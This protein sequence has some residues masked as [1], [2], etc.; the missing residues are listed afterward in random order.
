MDG[1]G[2]EIDESKFL[3]DM[4]STHLRINFVTLFINT[5]S[6]QKTAARNVLNKSNAYPHKKYRAGI[7]PYIAKR[8]SASLFNFCLSIADMARKTKGAVITPDADHAAIKSI[9]VVKLLTIA[10]RSRLNV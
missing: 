6:A 2:S 3:A 5:D 9:L 4:Q 1:L 8:I 10:V 7:G